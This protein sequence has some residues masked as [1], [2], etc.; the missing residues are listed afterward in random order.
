MNT[1]GKIGVTCLA[2]GVLAVGSAGV[3]KVVHKSGGPP[4]Y[5]AS[6]PATT[7]P[8]DTDAQQAALAFLQGWA[9]GP[10]RYQEAADGTDAP[11]AAAAALRGYHD[12]LGLTSVAL[13]GTAVAGPT[14]GTSNGAHVTFTVTAHVSGG[15]WSYADG[16]DVLRSSNGAEAVHW[17]STVLHPKL[18]PGQSLKAGTLPSGATG[19]TVLGD[20]G[21]TVLTAARYPSLRDI[22]TTVGKSGVGAGGTA[23]TGVA[24]VD[25][26]GAFVSA[27]KTFTRGKPGTFTTTIDPKLQAVAEQAVK[28]KPK[29]SVVALDYTTGRIKAVAYNGPAGNTAFM[30]S[31]APG[32][33]MKMITSAAVIDKLGLTP[34][35]PAPCAKTISAGGATFH[36]DAGESDPTADL[37]RAFAMSCNTAFIHVGYRMQPG[38]LADEAKNVFGIGTDW[39]V[40]GGVFVQDGSVPDVPPDNA[41][42][43]ADL[44]GQGKVLM[45]P[46]AVASVAATI[47][48]SHYHQ[49]VI[50]PGQAQKP[51]ARPMSAGTAAAVRQLMRAAAGPGGTAA[52]RMAGINGGAKTG[53]SEV[54]QNAETTNG[55]FAAYDQDDHIAV[56]ALVIGGKTGADSAGYIAR[57]VL[58]G[59]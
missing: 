29:S 18:H 17:A 31:A 24:V 50:L 7:P 35:S 48:D 9:A 6:S 37:K 28:G 56:G 54:G 22:I 47:A 33:T 38:D 14:A 43:A 11:A 5:D 36:N 42:Q 53:T 21:R 20:D 26:K 51:A 49:P 8:S 16:L 39:S 52:A 13:T 2:V 19:A 34:S 1:A 45:N 23:G 12:G 40:G 44:I 10:A 57:D 27:A 4:R 59:P 15:T 55:W 25:A 32:S 30:G 41:T 58:L 3:Y 46:L